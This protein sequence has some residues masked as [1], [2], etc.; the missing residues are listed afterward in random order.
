VTAVGD[1]AEGF[2]CFAGLQGNI[3]LCGDLDRDFG[4]AAHVMVR[5]GDP[6]GRLPRS[7]APPLPRPS[8]V[9]TEGS[10]FLSWVAEKA[11]EGEHLNFASTAPGG[12]V[13]GF[14][15][16][17]GLRRIRTD[18][19]LSSEGLQG[20]FTKGPQIGLEIGFGRET[21]PRGPGSGTHLQPFQ[22]EGVSKYFFYDEGG[23]TVGTCTANFYE[24]R[25][26]ATRLPGLE[27]QA[28]LR[29][30][31]YGTFV[32][33]TGCF[34]GIRG[35]LYGLGRSLFDPTR[36]AEHVISNLYVARVDDPAGRLLLPSR[37][38]NDS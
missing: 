21:A 1:V 33:G 10:T 27:G 24:G 5:I 28:A 13:R 3:V 34:A 16:P 31:Y 23:R 19:V 9:T 35:L 8:G 25:S 29:F 6:E 17:V 15:I 22:F 37:S 26:F 38:T 20:V 30:G 36:P 12:D 14:N 4:L 18:L 32:D 2:G 7:A 11:P